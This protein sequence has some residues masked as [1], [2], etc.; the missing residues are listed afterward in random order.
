MRDDGVGKGKRRG[1]W[2][3]RRSTGRLYRN[4]PTLERKETADSWAEGREGIYHLP[5]ESRGYV[6]AQRIW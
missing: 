4:L 1:D 5:T 6:N 2:T 3:G